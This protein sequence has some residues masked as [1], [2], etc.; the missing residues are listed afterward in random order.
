MDKCSSFKVNFDTSE[1]ITLADS[2]DLRKTSKCGG[3]GGDMFRGESKPK[4]SVH[5]TVPVW[6]FL[7]LIAYNPRVSF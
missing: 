1:T 7:R 4:V 5:N 6:D 3:G 2:L